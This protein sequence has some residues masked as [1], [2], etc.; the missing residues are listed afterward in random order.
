MDSLIDFI[1]QISQIRTNTIHPNM[2]SGTGTSLAQCCLTHQLYCWYG[3]HRSDYL[4]SNSR[5]AF[6]VDGAGKIP[7]GS[8]V[9]LEKIKNLQDPTRCYKDVLPD[10]VFELVSS[11][12]WK[13]GRLAGPVA[14]SLDKYKEAAIQEIWIINPLSKETMVYFLSESG[15]YEKFVFK[16]EIRITCRSF[17]DLEIDV[18]AIYLDY[19]M[20]NGITGDHPNEMYIPTIQI[21]VKDNI[22]GDNNTV[23][24][25]MTGG[26]VRVREPHD[27]ESNPNR[28]RSKP[29]TINQ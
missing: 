4:I 21:T 3:E 15:D 16:N 7:D 26:I 10:V 25:T 2:A 5:S 12:E 22:F 24:N 9:S 11:S 18:G 14:K 28:I 17:D 27:E 29:R 1:R 20:I 6:I 13:G 19:E 23:I 8:I